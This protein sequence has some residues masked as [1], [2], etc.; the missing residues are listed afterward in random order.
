MVVPVFP[1]DFPQGPVRFARD[2]LGRSFFTDP[3]TGRRITS[4]D[5]LRRVTYDF[6]SG[7]IRDS[8]GHYVGMAALRLPGSGR[9][10]TL[11]NMDVIYSNLIRDP[12]IYRVAGNE[13]LIERLVVVERNGRLRTVNIS[14]GL[15][16]NYDPARSG[17][18]WAAELASSTGVKPGRPEAYRTYK[19]AVLDRTFI[20][21]TWR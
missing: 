1:P 2:R 3:D 9:V 15:G 17:K 5:A 18:R 4:D 8:F 6:R 19:E 7:R 20:I 21:K 14:Y 16:R 13:E 10:V 11:P 12:R